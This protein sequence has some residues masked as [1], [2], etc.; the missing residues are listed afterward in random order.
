MFET[1]G[2]PILLLFVLLCF[3]VQFQ[4]DVMACFPFFRG[5]TEPILRSSL[6]IYLGLVLLIPMVKPNERIVADVQICGVVCM[7]CS[8]RLGNCSLRHE[9]EGTVNCGG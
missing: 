8:S 4:H 1:D 6:Y 3:Q 5:L 9:G 7:V 2:L